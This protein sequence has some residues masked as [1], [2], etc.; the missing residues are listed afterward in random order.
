VVIKLLYTSTRFITPPLT[1]L[2]QTKTRNLS[3]HMTC[4]PS[5]GAVAQGS[6]QQISPAAMQPWQFL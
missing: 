2:M 4:S 6:Q 1:Q 5:P 3:S